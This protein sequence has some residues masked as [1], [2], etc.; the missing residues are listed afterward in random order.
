[1]DT[2]VA[3][4]LEK[5]FKLYS[6]FGIKSVTMD[7][8]ASH[9]G[10]SKKTL[11]EHFSDKEDLVRQVMMLEHTSGCNFM[12][13]IR[14]RE[15]NALEELFELYKMIH[16]MFRE[17]NP[18]MEYDIRKYYPDLF[19]KVREIRRSRIYD[20]MH[21]N[22]VK[23]I[24][25]GLFR[26]DINAETIARLH[27]FHVENLFESDLF[28]IEEL[29]TFSVFHEIFVYHL[30]G[31]LSHGGRALFESQFPKFSDPEILQQ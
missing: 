11:Y 28:P 14:Q 21:S 9:L 15:M 2:K 23:G 19:L 22:I 20:S 27:V 8:V 31:I 5:V 16:T 10:I 25:E 18:S 26:H 13:I 29:T 17:Y 4:I 12:E 30:N 24:N 6:R 1:M 3:G 7:D